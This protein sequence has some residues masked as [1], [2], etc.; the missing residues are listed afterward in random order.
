MSILEENVNLTIQK[1]NALHDFVNKQDWG[2]LKRDGFV[3][4]LEKSVEKIKEVFELMK[5]I[6][7]ETIMLLEKNTPDIN[8]FLEKIERE[9]IIF[10]S[11]IKMEKTKRMRIELINENEQVDV[12]ELYRT[13]QNK[14][15]EL[16]LKARYEIEKINKFMISR[17]THF[18]KKGSTAKALIEILQKR[19]EELSEIRKKNVELKRKTFFKAEEASIAEIEEELHEKD[20]VLEESVKETKKAL[21][22]HLAQINYVEGSF[23]NLEKKISYIESI[24]SDFTKKTIQLIIGLKKERDYARKTALEI[25]EETLKVR[26]EHTNQIINLND[27]K[28]ILKEEMEKNYSR[29]IKRLKKE[30]EEKNIPI[31]NMQNLIE[32]QEKEI[33]KL[34]E[35][36]NFK[37]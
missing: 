21:K 23:S 33:K 13:L 16:S 36:T 17:K 14:L 2:E 7:K 27:Q 3:F 31:K 6:N 19:E 29:E 32:M 35:K 18:V 22:T 15:L 10:E 5:Q 30:L 12:P 20:K 37:K 28:N 1:I 25:E 26:Q 24:H 9:I 8:P 11:N 4:E 34:K